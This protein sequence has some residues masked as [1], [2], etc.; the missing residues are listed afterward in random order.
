MTKTTAWRAINAAGGPSA[1]ADALTTD[2]QKI[3]RTRVWNWTQPARCI[4]AEHVVKICQLGGYAFQPRQLRP[5]VFDE[6]HDGV[7]A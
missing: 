1:V 7:K 6:S 2:D 3:S 4:P 5:D